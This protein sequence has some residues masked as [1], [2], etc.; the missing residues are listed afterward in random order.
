M[1]AK[2]G[3]SGKAVALLLAIVLVIGCVAGGTIAYLIADSKTVTNTFVAGEIGELGL[4]ESDDDKTY[5]VVPGVDINKDPTVSYTPATNNDIG[6]VYIFVQVTDTPENNRAWTYDSATNKFVT[7]AGLS[8]TVDSQWTYLAG[9]DNV[10]WMLANNAVEN[11]AIIA[12]DTIDVPDTLTKETITAAANDATGLTFTAYAIQAA[13]DS[14]A[15]FTPDEA[16][17]AV[18]PN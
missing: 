12:G 5:T 13:K 2:K 4:D 17:T 10:F 15:K 9:S 1:Y 11:Q 14:N 16:W 3:M 8:W 7:T 18:K 6:E